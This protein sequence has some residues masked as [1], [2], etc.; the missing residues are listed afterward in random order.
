MTSTARQ[1]HQT[2]RKPCKLWE[3]SSDNTS[4]S[5]EAVEIEIDEDTDSEAKFTLDRWDRWFMS[6]EDEVDSDIED[7]MFK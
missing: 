3:K 6:S 5:Q 4:G 2:A 7:D 1:P